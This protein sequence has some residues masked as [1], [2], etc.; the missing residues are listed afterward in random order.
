M[1]ER[2]RERAR[3]ANVELL[4]LCFFCFKGWRAFRSFLVCSLARSLVRSF[5][6]SLFLAGTG[7]RSSQGL[8]KPSLNPKTNSLSDNFDSLSISYLRPAGRESHRKSHRNRDREKE[9][10]KERERKYTLLLALFHSS[11]AERKES[12]EFGVRQVGLEASLWTCTI[13]Q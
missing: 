4:I 1:R 6:R 13:R 11:Q 12:G 3:V 7:P 10:E 5:V 9:R 2:G 8:R